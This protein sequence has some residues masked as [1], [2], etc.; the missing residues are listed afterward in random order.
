MGKETA[1]GI[2]NRRFER[3]NIKLDIKVTFEINGEKRNL[4]L[5][6]R[7]LSQQ[8]I[9]LEATQDQTETL[10]IISNSKN[11]KNTPFD[12]EIVLPRTT[13]V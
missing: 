11:F 3:L 6:S 10:D 12:M 4:K 2:N 13:P 1:D 9:C 7:N 8:G 5:K